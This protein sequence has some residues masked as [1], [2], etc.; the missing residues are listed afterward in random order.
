VLLSL[1]KG[2]KECHC[3]IY[4]DCR[5]CWNCFFWQLRNCLFWI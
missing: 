5:T 3:K 1:T 2:Y 4:C